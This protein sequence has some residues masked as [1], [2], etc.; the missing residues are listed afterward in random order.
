MA[1]ATEQRAVELSMS[2]I[3]DIEPA[4]ERFEIWEYLLWDILDFVVHHSIVKGAILEQIK[5]TVEALK[6]HNQDAKDEADLD[7]AK[8]QAKKAVEPAQGDGFEEFCDEGTQ[9]LEKQCDD[10]N[11]KYKGKYLK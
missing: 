7:D 5:L 11:Y 2:T 3:L 4:D 9:H 6:N 10:N 8:Y 1:R